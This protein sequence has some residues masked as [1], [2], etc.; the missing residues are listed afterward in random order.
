MGTQAKIV[1]RYAG[2]H[3][4]RVVSATNQAEAELVQ[5]L[6]L[7][8]GIPSM[9]QRTRGFDV[10][11][12]L[13]AGPRDVMVP[14]AGH[15]AARDVLLLAEI[16]PDE[17]AAVAPPAHLPARGFGGLLRAMRILPRSGNA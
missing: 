6:L 13:A 14:A 10:P 8:E 1:A 3:L 5:G 4:A 9:L 17:P 15:A 11:D 12:M 2:G 7:E 16:L